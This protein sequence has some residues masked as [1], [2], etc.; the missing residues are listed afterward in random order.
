[1]SFSIVFFLVYIASIIPIGGDDDDDDDKHFYLFIYL[2]IN[3]FIFCS[4]FCAQLLLLCIILKKT[5]HPFHFENMF[6]PSQ[7]SISYRN[8]QINT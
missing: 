4:R 8:I 1:M 2:F 7:Q 3:L 6:R 5:Q